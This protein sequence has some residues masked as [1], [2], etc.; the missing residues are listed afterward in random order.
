[1][2]LSFSLN[3]CM[4]WVLVYPTIQA[5]YQYTYLA[6]KLLREIVIYICLSNE[7]GEPFRNYVSCL[8]IYFSCLASIK[9]AT[10]FSNIIIKAIYLKNGQN[11]ISVL[12]MARSDTPIRLAAHTR[13]DT[14][15]CPVHISC[16][17]QTGSPKGD[18]LFQEDK[19]R[20]ISAGKL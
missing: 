4:C 9:H 8:F 1:M 20:V 16:I 12:P 3:A 7:V 6:N 5:G 18:G 17:L 11:S 15:Y 14:P 10:T 2:C 13:W 19:E